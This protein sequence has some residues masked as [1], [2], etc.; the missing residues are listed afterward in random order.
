MKYQT[1]RDVKEAAKQAMQQCHAQ[2]GTMHNASSSTTELHRL[3]AA[4][5]FLCS[6]M[7][8]Y[9][10]T[11]ITPRL[12]QLLLPQCLHADQKQL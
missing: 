7:D 8:D 12:C 10:H 4:Y 2:W 9:S 5:E 3:D 1:A 6:S 11:G